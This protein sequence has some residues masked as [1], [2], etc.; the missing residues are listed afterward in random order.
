[1]NNKKL[2][3]LSPFKSVRKYCFNF[4]IS[5]TSLRLSRVLIAV[6]S[7]ASVFRLRIFSFQTRL[8]DVF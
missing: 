8:S 7:N 5:V 2:L 6:F 3:L 1:M 4:I